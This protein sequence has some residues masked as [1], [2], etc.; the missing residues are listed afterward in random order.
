MPNASVSTEQTGE[1]SYQSKIR[2]IPLRPCRSEVEIL[3]ISPI[4]S[5]FQE[6]QTRLKHA[7]YIY[8]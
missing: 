2:K 1:R 3:P 8:F 6:T 7:R 4:L 5:L